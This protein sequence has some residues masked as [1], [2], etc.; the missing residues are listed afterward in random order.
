VSGNLNLTII[1]LMWRI[2]LAPNNASK[3][4]MGF[5]SV[6]KG[7]SRLPLGEQPCDATDPQ[8]RAGTHPCL[9]NY[10][11]QCSKCIVRLKI[12]V[13]WDITSCRLRLVYV[14]T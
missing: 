13:L 9:K 10:K 3:W 11:C 6:F 4:Q 14:C 12:R 5:N 8:R 1:L 7:L 2:W